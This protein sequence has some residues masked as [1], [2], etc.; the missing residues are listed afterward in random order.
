[1][2]SPGDSE[3]GH[4]WG[5]LVTIKMMDTG[6]PGHNEGENRWRF[7]DDHEEYESR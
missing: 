6:F 3:D 4:R 5:F 2:G 7:R 1:M